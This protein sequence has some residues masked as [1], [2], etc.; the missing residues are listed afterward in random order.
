ML[1]SGCRM[2]FEGDFVRPDSSGATVDVP[3]PPPP[4][5]VEKLTVDTPLLETPSPTS[6]NCGAFS[7]F[8]AG[9]DTRSSNELVPY[10]FI[11]N[12]GQTLW[13]T[14]SCKYTD[15]G[16]NETVGRWVPPG[17]TFELLDGKP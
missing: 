1:L 16:W 15:I 9:D 17:G 3:P 8:F 11:D 5:V 7:M 10:A 12:D 13:F 6:S 2:G 4:G 14:L